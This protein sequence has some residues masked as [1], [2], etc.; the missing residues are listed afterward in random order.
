MILNNILHKKQLFEYD[1]QN[2]SADHVQVAPSTFE[3]LSQ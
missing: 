3:Y 2:R 1:E